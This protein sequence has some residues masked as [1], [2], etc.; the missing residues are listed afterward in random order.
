LWA[1][2]EETIPG[3]VVDPQQ[4]VFGPDETRLVL[5]FNRHRDDDGPDAA[6]G[7]LQV[8][9]IPGR[10]V[11]A[12][13]LTLAGTLSD[14]QF[15]SDGRAF[16]T[17]VNSRPRK[18]AQQTDPDWGETS[19]WNSGSA[20][21]ITA[22]IRHADHARA[23]FSPDGRWIAT[24]CDDGTARVWDTRSGLPRTPP[25]VLS[26]PATE[27]TFSGDGRLLAIGTYDAGVRVWDA[28]S[29]EPV[30]PPLP[31]A[32]EVSD[33][34]FI[35]DDRILV[36]LARSLWNG[37][38]A[39]RWKLDRDSAD[40]PYDALSKLLSLHHVD[41]TGAH[42]AIDRSQLAELWQSPSAAESAAAR[43]A[44]WHQQLA[45][46]CAHADFRDGAAAHLDWLID[47]QP[48]AWKPLLNRGAVRQRRTFFYTH[49][50]P[51]P[52]WQGVI[53]DYTAAIERAPGQAICRQLRADA[54]CEIGDLAA[55]STDLERLWQLTGRPEW[56]WRHALARLGTGDIEA[57]RQPR[58]RRGRHLGLPVADRCGGGR[59]TA[60]TV[61]RNDLPAAGG[62]AAR[63]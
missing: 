30:T 10:Q 56:G 53:A 58:S 36:A 17:S 2:P 42:V 29:G 55:A 38:V 41:A 7:E 52:D 49:F 19:I 60:L 43:L 48:D 3:D 62:P 59:R 40:R 63:P 37:P 26:R 9:D 16:L 61:G 46:A 21:L 15:C 45:T 18:W 33:L 6:T 35:D 54:Y 34:R 5:G 50:E 22:P 44:A 39:V 24:V 28:T 51:A 14:V 31:G 57:Y 27:V 12:E 23:V 1:S 4:I 11:L 13:T 8:L 47:R 25:I 20:E 32:E